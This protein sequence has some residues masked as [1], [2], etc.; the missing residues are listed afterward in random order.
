M[1]GSIRITTGSLLT[2]QD[3]FVILHLQIHNSVNSL[4]TTNELEPV[5]PVIAVI[6]LDKVA[7]SDRTL[8][9]IR[10]LGRFFY[11]PKFKKLEE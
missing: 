3:N 10:V 5:K 7:P 8:S 11:A 2:R 4:L 1:N 6:S 9:N